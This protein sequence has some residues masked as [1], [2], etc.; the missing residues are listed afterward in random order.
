MTDD[1][2]PVDGA[3]RT[4]GESRVD[5]AGAGFAFPNAFVNVVAPLP[6]ARRVTTAGRCGG[7]SFTAVDHLHAGRPLPHW[8]ARL[9]APGRVPPDGHLLADLVQRR[10]LDSF[11]SWS[12]LR[13]LTWSLL[14]DADAGPLAGV[15]TLTRAEVP[16]VLRAL[17][18]GRP[19]VL[20]LVT[21]RAV[22]RS[23][24]NHQVVAHAHDRDAA[25]RLRLHVL[26][27]N[28]PGR[29]ATLTATGDGWQGS[30]GR[31]WRGLFLHSWTPRRPPVLPSASRHPSTPVRDG[32]TVRL[33]HVWSGRGLASHGTAAAVGPGRTAT[34]RLHH[35]AD[36]ADPTRSVAAGSPFADG[37]RVV[38]GVDPPRRHLV[39]RGTGADLLP[40]AP[41]AWRVLVDGGGRWR[42]GDRVRLV[43]VAT[44]QVLRVGPG[45]APR[46]PVRAGAVA[47]ERAWWTVGADV[48]GAAPRAGASAPGR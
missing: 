40:G 24:D 19:V 45:H 6:G 39:L 31:R 16:G 22:V 42:Q 30:D 3:G 4:A 28:Q 2:G 23:G 12:A 44:G 15:R 13:F 29:D 10:Q 20:G 5:A 8:P 37:D 33:L 47:D 14:P 32:D 17:T 27:P 38:L 26:D 11:A 46:L 21:A 18:S 43:H 7:M 1:A 48:D 9:F 35:A 25:G 34:W 41:E 36:A